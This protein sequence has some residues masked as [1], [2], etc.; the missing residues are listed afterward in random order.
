MILL[1]QLF[2]SEDWAGRENV[3]PDFSMLPVNVPAKKTDRSDKKKHIASSSGRATA[4]SS[5]VP[6]KRMSRYRKSSTSVFSP[7]ENSPFL[8][9]CWDH[10]EV[11]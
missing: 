2:C 5:S 8:M 9:G 6:V 7:Q 11:D 10:S 1:D 3:S 4:A